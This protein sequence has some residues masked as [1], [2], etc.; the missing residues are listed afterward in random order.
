M[1]VS[2]RDLETIEL[3]LRLSIIINT[4][5]KVCINPNIMHNYVQPAFQ[6]N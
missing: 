1:G 3:E 5:V 6:M 2:K 4:N